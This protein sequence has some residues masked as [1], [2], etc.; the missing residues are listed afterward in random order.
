MGGKQSSYRAVYGA[1]LACIVLVFLNFTASLSPLLA[2]APH[3]LQQPTIDGT[4]LSSLSNNALVETLQSA[5]ASESSAQM[6]RKFFIVDAPEMSTSLMR[7]W[8]SDAVI[9]YDKCLNEEAIE[10]WLHRGFEKLVKS[11]TFDAV[12]ASAILIPFY[13]HFSIGLR[14]H[15]PDLE[16]FANRLLQNAIQD[17]SKPHILLCPSNNPK[18]GRDAG[19]SKVM[20]I[21][22][23]AGVNMWSVGIERNPSWQSVNAS[24]IIPIPY[25]VKPAGSISELKEITSQKR[26]NSTVFYAG[27]RRPNAM[28]W[29][30][31]NRSMVEPLKT[32]E[33]AVIKLFQKGEDR[34]SQSE[35]NDF[36][37]TMEFCLI[38]CGDT[39]TSR[40]LASSVIHGCIPLRIGSRLRGLCEK[41][42][43]R[44]FGWTITGP[45]APHLPYSDRIPWSEFPEVN[46]AEFVKAPAITLKRATDSYT[47]ERKQELREILAKVQEGWIYG[48]G[49]PVTSN[50]FGA[51]A[52]YAWD[53]FLFMLD[54]RRH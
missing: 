47:S 51:V 53:S 13:G 38:L 17:K 49:S 36:M 27:D 41:P 28:G 1:L 52:E 21:L 26:I 48:W 23:N 45:K 5:K 34:I 46:E 30:G 24:R 2:N 11:R 32:E 33:T 42:C 44:G 9:F 22:K 3:W 43:K 6:P 25:L 14:D 54:T 20:E 10:I 8:S 16:V 7:N 37:K 31:C 15:K 18:R 19:I 40:S 29:S 35:Y 50:D 4:D 12:E 39:P